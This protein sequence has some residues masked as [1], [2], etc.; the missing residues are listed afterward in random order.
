MNIT[1]IGLD[2]AKTVFQVH[3]VDAHG[4]VVGRKQLSRRKVRP[5]FAQLPPCLSGLEACGGAPYWGRELG[6]LNSSTLDG[7]CYAACGRTYAESST[8]NEV[9]FCNQA[10]TT[11]SNSSMV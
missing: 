4:K 3:G 7:K 10:N 6:K 5:Y 1:T 9:R 2:L 11:S 8:T